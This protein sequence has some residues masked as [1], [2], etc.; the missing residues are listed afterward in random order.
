MINTLSKIWKN[1]RKKRKIQLCILLST[2]IASGLAEIFSLAALMPV[3]A[4]LTNSND[5]NQYRFIKKVSLIFGF[6]STNQIILFT[7]IVFCVAALT[8]AIVRITNLWLSSRTAAA[9]GSDL[10]CEIY[11]RSLYQPY[12]EHLKRNTSEV[13]SNSTSQI[14]TTIVVLNLIL[15]VFTSSIIGFFLLAS[16]II[17]DWKITLM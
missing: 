5:I 9:I 10:S 11:K 1:L 17:L 13:I 16:L 12:I 6:N 8:S 7:T 2:M 14:G 3:L 15:Q 4:A